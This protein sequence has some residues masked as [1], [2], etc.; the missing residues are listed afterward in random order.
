[1]DDKVTNDKRAGTA[2]MDGNNK[3]SSSTNVIALA[4][5]AV[6]SVHTSLSWT[7]K[8]IIDDTVCSIIN[9]VNFVSYNGIYFLN[10]A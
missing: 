8:Y 4:I 3:P 7:Y 1:M 10:E 5:I 9:I 2:E 6:A